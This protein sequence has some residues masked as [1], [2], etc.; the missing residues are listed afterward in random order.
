MKAFFVR[1]RSILL[2]VAIIASV[3]GCATQPVPSGIDMPGFWMGMV[4]GFLIVFS[5]IGSFFSDIRIYAFPNA[6]SF[7]DLGYVIGAMMSLG[8]TGASVR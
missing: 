2:A 7:Y 4:H 6:G 3:I 8:G 1:H 5:L